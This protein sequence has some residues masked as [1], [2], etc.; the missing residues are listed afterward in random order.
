[1]WPGTL[2]SWWAASCRHQV[3]EKAPHVAGTF[4]A[5][6][7]GVGRTI[8][9][10]GTRLDGD[11]LGEDPLGAY[12]ASAAVAAATF[13]APGALEKPCAVSYGPVPGSVYAGHR[14]IDVLIHGWDL[15]VA[16]RQNTRMDP[17][18]VEACLA[19]L[20]PQ[21][22]QLKASG[23]FGTDVAVPADADPQTRLLAML[24]RRQSAEIAPTGGA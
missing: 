23:A 13:E 24:G 5:P 17:S 19:V 11:V 7:L 21:F 20:E 4:W 18:L 12:D 16:T 1:M 22:D 14:F 15:A 6:E 9:E 10:V 8:A 3:I 2:L